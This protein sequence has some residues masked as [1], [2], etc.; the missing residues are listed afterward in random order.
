MQ[1]GPFPPKVA[2]DI[3]GN[4]VKSTKS[5]S[6]SE[7]GQAVFPRDCLLQARCF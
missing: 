1:T 5:R 4:L 3:N 6:H 2:A 7:K